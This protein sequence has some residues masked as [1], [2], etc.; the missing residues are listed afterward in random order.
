[1][2]IYLDLVEGFSCEMCGKC[3]RNS[4][5][6]TVDADSYE[7]NKDLFRKIGK[8][9]EFIQ[10]FI[11][12]TAGAGPGEYACIA[13]KGDGSCWFLE[14]DNRCRL[15]REAGHSHLDGVCQTFPRYPM[16]TARGIE[17]TLSFSCPAVLRMAVR[18]EPFAII[19]S[20]KPPIEVYEQNCVADV[21]PRQKPAAN[22][23]RYYFELEQH[24]IDIL[25]CR[26][27]LVGNRLNLLFQTI[28][29]IERYP[30]GEDIR[31]H[32]DQIFR[33][34]YALMDSWG[35]KEY[36]LNKSEVLIENFFV[37]MVFKKVFYL[38]GL[39]P[40][41]LFIKH[42]WQGIEPVY[43]MEDEP[44]QVFRQVAAIIADMEF[45]YGHDRAA[46]F[47]SVNNGEGHS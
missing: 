46:F 34:N 11:P 44:E 41:A 31:Q 21:F 43:L 29:A 33:G 28:T 2:Y 39:S 47:K 35:T 24:F 19:R 12:L 25:Q 42:I 40:A 18:N 1:M 7:R 30:Q 15:H 3:C 26:T 4:W 20:E 36:P 32:L 27:A 16:S 5:M 17:I 45:H 23:L 14:Q 37:N 10:A 6:V 22:V 13:K 9:S 8:E 38:Y